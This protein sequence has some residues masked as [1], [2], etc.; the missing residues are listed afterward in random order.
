MDR[1]EKRHSDDG[2]GS[3]GKGLRPTG[4][5]AVHQPSRCRLAHSGTSSRPQCPLLE[6]KRT[7]LQLTSMSAF[8]PKRTWDRFFGFGAFCHTLRAGAVLPSG[9]RIL[10]LRVICLAK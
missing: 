9:K 8:D 2:P 4:P 5:E 10:N 3:R 7:F 6:V 1:T